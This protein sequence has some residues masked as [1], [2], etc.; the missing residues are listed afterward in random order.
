MDSFSIEGFTLIDKDFF[1]LLAFRL[2][3]DFIFI[4][5]AVKFIYHKISKNSEYSFTFLTINILL[6]FTASMLTSL[7]IQTGFAFGLFAVLSILRYRTY[8]IAIMEMTFLFLSIILAIIN[9]MVTAQLGFVEILFANISV[10]ALTYI[11]VVNRTKSSVLSMP[12]TYENIDL[13]HVDKRSELIAD[14]KK[15]T[16]LNITDVNIYRINYLRDT[17]DMN[18]YYTLNENK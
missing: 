4:F 8:P 7:K 16:G 12:V 14:L 13:I 11:M 17:A 2:V 18:V 10:V 5:F 1:S 6:F 3:I 15:R 9:S